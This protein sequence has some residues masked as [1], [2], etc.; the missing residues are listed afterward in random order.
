L[1]DDTRPG[2]N[3]YRLI[4]LAQRAIESC[5][6]CL[7]NAIVLTEAAT[8]AYAV[9]PVIAAMA[10]AIRVFALAQD[11]RYGTIEEI[12]A[13]TQK[14]AEIAGISDRIKFITE[15]SS[16]IISQAD[17]ITN[18]GYVRPI[19]AETIAW[20]KPTAVIPLMYEAWEFRSDDIDIQACRQRGIKVAGTNE[21]HPSVDVFSFLGLMAI[22]LLLDAGVSIYNSNV[23]LLCDNHFSVF[24]QRSLS[25]AGAI[26]ETSISFSSISKTRVYDAIVVALQPKSEPVLS[27]ADASL[28]A[29]HWPGTVIAQFWGDIDRSAF[30]S[31]QVPVWPPNA[32]KKGHMA[33]LPSAIGPEPI[34]KLQ[35]GGLKVGELLWRSCQEHHTS[36][37]IDSYKEVLNSGFVD[38]IISY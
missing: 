14:L 33:I 25:N 11:S 34:I 21:R 8:G 5:N 19:D 18:S 15:K 9:T 37:Q 38:E 16:E 29:Q 10:G 23:L 7:E 28:I 26:V 12:K 35:T 36:V 4:N 20:M 3:L 13:Q 27:A 30:L 17:I 31:S 1:I 2:L 32:P 22:K 6:L 24:I